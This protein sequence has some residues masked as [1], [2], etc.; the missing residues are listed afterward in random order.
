MLKKTVLQDRRWT[1]SIFTLVFAGLLWGVYQ[2]MDGWF[3][4]LLVNATRVS[5]TVL[6]A[7]FFEAFLAALV[8]IA[9]WRPE[10]LRPVSRLRSRLGRLRWVLVI[11]FAIGGGL[12][13]RIEN[14]QM[15][16]GSFA[17]LSLT[18]FFLGGASWLATE[19]DNCNW[20]MRGVLIGGLLFATAFMFTVRLQKVSNHPFSL[21]WS[22]GNR[23]WDYSIPFGRRLYKYPAG[24]E[25][26]SLTD[27]GRRTLWGIPYLLPGVQIWMVRF[28]DVL[29]FTVPYALLGWSVFSEERK[30]NRGLFLLLGLWTMLFLTQGPI[31]SPLVLAAIIV[32]LG[33]KSPYWLNVVL[34]LIASYYARTSRYTWMFAPG[35]WAAM[36]AFMDQDWELSKK[37]MKNWLQPVLLGVAGIVGGYLLPELVIQLTGKG[38]S[39]AGLFTVEGMAET[40]GRQPLLWNRLLPN[41][42]YSSGILLGLFLAAAPLVIVVIYLIF[43]NK[44]KLHLWQKLAGAV[45]MAA[46][47]GVGVV[48]SV[49]I[50]GGNN[51]HNLD[52][53]LIGL[54]MLAG[55]CWKNGGRNLLLGIG[56]NSIWMNII[57]LGLVLMPAA[58]VIREPGISLLPPED[59]VSE[60]LMETQE[61]V[62]KAREDGD[63]L[64]M[65]QRQLL[66]FGHVS[67]VPLVVD[68]EKKLLM[69][70]AMAAN[71]S[72]FEAYYQDLVYHRFALIISEPLRTE[73]Q[74]A[75]FDFGN[76]NDAWVK[77]VSIPMLC[78][79]EPIA[80][81][82][83]VGLELLVPRAE[84]VSPVAGVICPIP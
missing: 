70:E 46:F 25:I 1:T 5:F 29:M 6:T 27:I 58:K 79:Y 28:W 38:R 67:D 35:I 34:V 23:I 71:E 59:L 3:G 50:G 12:L 8:L 75:E 20:S 36:L 22:E 44:W 55:L 17:R 53:F 78:Y 68:Y 30:V 69:N 56:A 48:I 45:F 26:F 40:T 65:D 73:F 49:K 9:L 33:R 10:W 15:F 66:T 16:D 54:V 24:E 63:V 52:M 11:L 4:P 7:I 51:L 57:L 19:E 21:F 41:P 76:E 80:T 83:E 39:Q 81:Y 62:A 61:A 2:D 74:G 18:I 14:S 32:L 47:L 82:H 64:F 37:W 43:K 42:T 13:F 77:W 31:Y 60:A 72:Y 84:V